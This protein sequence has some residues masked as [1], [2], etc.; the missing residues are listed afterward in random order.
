MHSYVGVEA[1][2]QTLRAKY[3]KCFTMSTGPRRL[4]RFVCFYPLGP[5]QS[6]VLRWQYIL[7][8]VFFKP[9]DLLVDE[10]FK[11]LSCWVCNIHLKSQLI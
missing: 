10:E 6:V 8:S 1:G 3:S 4:V 7:E 9:G 5:I 11:A 2:G